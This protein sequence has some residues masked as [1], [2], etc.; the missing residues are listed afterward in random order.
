MGAGLWLAWGGGWDTRQPRP[1][2]P[3]VP[4]AARAPLALFTTLPLYWGEVRDPGTM[5]GASGPPHWVRTA[6]EGIADQTENVKFKAMLVRIKQDV[7]L[8]RR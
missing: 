7:L 6:I 8:T 1:G 4:H 5:L 2:S 3:P